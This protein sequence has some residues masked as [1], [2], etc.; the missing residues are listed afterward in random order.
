MQSDHFLIIFVEQSQANVSFRVAVTRDK[1][2]NGFPVLLD[3][4]LSNMKQKVKKTI[5]KYVE[6]LTSPKFR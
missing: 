3:A 5:P 4:F 6:M 2:V 1:V